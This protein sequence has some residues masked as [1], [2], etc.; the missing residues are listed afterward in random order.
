MSTNTLFLA[1][2]KSNVRNPHPSLSFTN[3][4]TSES[5]L[6]GAHTRV[7]NTHQHPCLHAAAEQCS[8]YKNFSTLLYS[9]KSLRASVSFMNRFRLHSPS[10]IYPKININKL[11]N[12]FNSIFHCNGANSEL[13]SLQIAC[14]SLA[15]KLLSQNVVAQGCNLDASLG[16]WPTRCRQMYRVS[17]ISHLSVN[18]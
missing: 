9:P 6:P 11:T 7:L 15:V 5:I 3:P 17:F 14:R 2:G 4:K 10:E 8:A 13:L 1:F 16:Q 18:S 12:L